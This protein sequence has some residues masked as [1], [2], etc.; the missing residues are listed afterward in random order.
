MTKSAQQKNAGALEKIAAKYNKSGKPKKFKLTDIQK[1]I[2]AG[3]VA[4]A[5]STFL[6]Y[7]ADTLNVRMQ[8]GSAR[9][10]KKTSNKFSRNMKK[11]KGLYRGVSLKMM[12]N[13]P[14]TG[15]TLGTYAATKRFLDKNY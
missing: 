1:D 4:G 8:A 15:I 2:T 3:L 12:K 7:P 6:T 11:F 10:Y 5:V 14:G 13:V 9:K